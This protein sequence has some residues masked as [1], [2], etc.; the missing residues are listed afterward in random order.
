[1]ISKV[2]QGVSLFDVC[3]I[4]MRRNLVAQGV[5]LFFALIHLE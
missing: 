5:K 1:M 2:L 4:R 3:T